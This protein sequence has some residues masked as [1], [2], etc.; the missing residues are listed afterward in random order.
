MK[1]DQNTSVS[2]T[3]LL[4][5]GGEYLTRRQEYLTRRQGAEYIRD[6]LG[7]PMS[8]STATKLAALG[9]FA[10]PTTWWGRRPLYSRQ[11]LQDWVEKRSGP[12]PTN[13]KLRRPIRDKPDAAQAADVTPSPVPS[14]LASPKRGQLAKQPS[15]PSPSNC[16]PPAPAITHSTTPSSAIG[17]CRQ[18]AGT[19][20]RSLG[21]VVAS[22][23]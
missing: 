8:F 3:A 21:S 18:C 15:D 1:N 13:D 23:S 4:G 20:R 11:S 17:R 22:G 16:A 2:A 9:E 12:T 7:R 5:P 19:P 6:E 14:E 10:E